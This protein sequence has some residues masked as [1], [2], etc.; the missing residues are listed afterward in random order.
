MPNFRNHTKDELN[1]VLEKIREARYEIIGELSITAWVTEEPVSFNNRKTGEKKELRTGDKWGNLFDCAWFHFTA[2]VPRKAKDKK[3]VLLID[4]NGELCVFDSAGMPVRGL[5]SKASIFSRELGAPTKRVLHI[6]NRSLEVGSVDIWADAGCNDLFGELQ[7]NGTVKEAFIAICNDDIRSF[8]YDFEVLYGLMKVLVPETAR[9]N[10]IYNSLMEA[11]FILKTF[12]SD[13]IQ[14]AGNILA[15]ELQ[16]LGGDPSLTI[17][18]V[19]HAHI[20]L[21]WLWPI[22]E[23]KRKG[24]RTF[25]TVLGLME[26]YPDYVFGASQPQ[27]FQWMKDSYPSLYEKIKER[28]KEGRLEVQ[29]AMWV[30]ADTNIPSGESLI[31]QIFYGKKFFRNE[32]GREINYLWEPDVFGYSAALP[33]I[34]KKSGVDYFITQKLSWNLINRYPH[35]SF[36]WKGIDGSEVLTHLLPEE[37]YNSP[38]SPGAVLKIEQNYLDKGVSDQCLMAFGI[39]DGG[40]GPGAEHLERLK[41]MKNL[42]GLCPVEQRTVTDFLAIWEKDKERF[43]TWD[44]ELYLERHQG[45][46]TTQCKSKWYNRRMEI[47]LRELEWKAVLSGLVSGAEY[48]AEPLERI[49]KEV[50]LYQFHDIIP[51]S[52]IKRVY[53]ESLQRYSQML[54]ETEKLISDHES[55][56]VKN[57]DTSSSKKPYV[58][59]NSLSWE[60]EEWVK[61]EKTWRKILVPAMGYVVI[62]GVSVGSLASNQ[63]IALTTKLENEFLV[64]IFNDDGSIKSIIDKEFQQEVLSPS[65]MGN[66]VSIY[67]DNGDAWDFSLTYREKK[68][69]VFVLINFETEID[70]PKASITHFYKYQK[71]EMK[72]QIVLIQGSRR[73]DFITWINWQE[74]AKM[75]KTS[76]PLAVKADHAVCE[77]QFGSLKRPTYSNTTWD[78]AKDEVPAQKWVD[79]SGRHYGVA[80]LNDSKYGYRVKDSTLELTLLRC[81]RYPGPLVDKGDSSDR[82]SGY[83]DLGEHNFTYSLYPHPGDYIEGAVVQAGY[84]LNIPLEIQHCSSGKGHLPSSFSYMFVESS[85][86]IIEMV[87]KA[88]NGSEIIVRLYESVGE[89]CKTGLQLNFPVTKALLVNLMEDEIGELSV[90]EGRVELDFTPFEILTLRLSVVW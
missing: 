38:A 5:T 1:G 59:Q 18:A 82:V 52:S 46:F 57:I 29:G 78:M 11:G 90:D 71:S 28:I 25:A 34:L 74:P 62:D 41:R 68:P 55:H 23:T 61:V 42:A 56:I 87:K 24:A 15:P 3:I 44:G 53:D 47:R 89:Q 16:K 51:G 58:I 49:W 45:T 77:I 80:L 60:R 64:I 50:L 8:Y 19:G 88:E 35:H 9:Y 70:G 7:E 86:V 67:E 84:E 30:E 81:V 79:I 4:V 14:K 75:I 69:D 73:I 26:R 63:P 31:R 22:R 13:E 36:K 32:F 17:S 6:S 65:G 48:P 83:T 54:E 72:Q 10:R 27:L 76:F 66:C 40:G 37:T 21:A 43:A 39:G 85:F 33:Q 20:D 2:D 12:S